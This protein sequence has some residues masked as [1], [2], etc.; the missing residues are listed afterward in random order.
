[1]AS[2]FAL[3][4]QHLMHDLFM[5]P[6]GKHPTL[7]TEALGA[8]RDIVVGMFM[9]ELKYVPVPR[10][11]GANQ[12]MEFT[13]D[14]IRMT[15]FDLLPEDIYVKQKNATN[16]HPTHI[17]TRKSDTSASRGALR[18]VIHKRSMT[19]DNIQYY[20]KRFKGPKIED[21][22]V[23]SVTMNRGFTVKID[24]TA[25]YGAKYG[26]FFCVK[27]VRCRIPSMKLKLHGSRYGFFAALFRPI[28]NHSMRK[29]T[30]QAMEENVWKQIGMLESRMHRVMETITMR[31]GRP[32]LS[33]K[34]AQIE[35]LV[36]VVD[37]EKISQRPA[38]ITAT[39]GTPSPAVGTGA[40]PAY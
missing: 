15:M 27:N 39:G 34:L 35:R 26:H 9:D 12:D 4:L 3:D 25:H 28:I 16:I 5:D 10:I 11:S 37:K 19:V 29:R 24:L 31:L 18:I 8:M 32:E 21:R 23:A 20:I 38:P 33:A 13:I 6:A 17:G 14:G 2:R 1:V 36:P 7:K 22:G 40:A 30:E